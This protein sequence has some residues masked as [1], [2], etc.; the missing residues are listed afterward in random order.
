MKY[1]D[2]ILSTENLSSNL[3][4]ETMSPKQYDKEFILNFDIYAKNNFF[5]IQ[6]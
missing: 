4:N 3:K 5:I 1:G 2:N 6:N